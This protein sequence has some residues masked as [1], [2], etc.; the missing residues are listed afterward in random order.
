MAYSGTSL[1]DFALYL[2]NQ[3]IDATRASFVIGLAET[4]CL[5]VVNPLPDGAE[6][7]VLDV[8]GRAY[9]NPNAI[10]SNGLAVYTEDQGPFNDGSPGSV[11]GG[12]WLTANNKQTLRELNTAG[13]PSSG[14]FAVDMTPAGAT[15]CTPW[16]DSATPWDWS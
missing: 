3:D 5:T 1:D 4:L 7:V 2:N 15:V 10:R 6:V 11:G 12:L 8:A 13:T 16:W 9:A 14:A